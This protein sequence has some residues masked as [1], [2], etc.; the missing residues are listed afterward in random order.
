MDATFAAAKLLGST[1]SYSLSIVA[2]CAFVVIRLSWGYRPWG[3]QQSYSIRETLSIVFPLLAGV[4]SIIAGIFAVQ[5]TAD[6][7]IVAR[8]NHP[9]AAYAAALAL[10]GL[11]G[12][13]Y[14][15]LSHMR[16]S[17]RRYDIL[18]TSDNA[19]TASDKYSQ[20]VRVQ[21]KGAV[22]WL[23]AF[24]I[25]ILWLREIANGH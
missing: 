11:G 1:F 12:L 7:L 21:A 15:V 10:S 24:G 4:V 3:S 16:E 14:V 19:L 6:I 22:G 23:F 9:W 20:L 17:R 2:V 25:G 13:T 8:A 5:E 18:D